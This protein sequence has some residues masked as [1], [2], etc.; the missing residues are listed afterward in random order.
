MLSPTAAQSRRLL[1]KKV[2]ANLAGVKNWRKRKSKGPGFSRPL[3]VLCG[4]QGWTLP[5]PTT[6]GLL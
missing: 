4:Q 2:M 6:W 3:G 5:L 1:Q